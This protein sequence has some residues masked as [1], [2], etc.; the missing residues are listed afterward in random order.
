LSLSGAAKSHEPQSA[1]SNAKPAESA[2]T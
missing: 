2:D 1:T